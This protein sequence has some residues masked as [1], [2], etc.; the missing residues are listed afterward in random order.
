LAHKKKKSK[1]NVPARRNA[2]PFYIKIVALA[3]SLFAVGLFL[4]GTLYR[5]GAPA[6]TA[7]SYRRAAAATGNEG[8]VQLVVSNFG[9]AC[10]ECDL[11]LAECTC[12]KPRGASEQKDYI[13]NKLREGMTAEQVA[14]AVDEF[15]GHRR[16]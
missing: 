1:R 16:A 12:D 13:R 14:Q 11:P 8:E 5:G 2:K 15:Y 9:C 4:F 10:G 3:A 6:V 7:G